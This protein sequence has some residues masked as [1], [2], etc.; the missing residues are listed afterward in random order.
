MRIVIATGNKDKVREI[1]EL[2]E[3]TDFEAVSMKE[4][5]ISCEPIRTDAFTGKRMTFFADPD[6]LPLEL[7]E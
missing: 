5:G 2:L 4:A 3:G 6:G 7:H 1:N